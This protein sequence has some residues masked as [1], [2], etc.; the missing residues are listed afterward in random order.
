MM[1]VF[2]WLMREEQPALAGVIVM[3]GLKF[4]MDKNA[5]SESASQASIE[6]AA[7]KAAAA[8]LA[9]AREANQTPTEVEVVNTQ[10]TPVPIVHT[11][12]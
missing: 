11:K 1:L 6:E 9:V 12:P 10:E 5:T 3:A 4:W 8:V 7:A 2:A